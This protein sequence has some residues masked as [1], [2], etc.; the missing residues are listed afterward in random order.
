M[1]CFSPCRVLVIIPTYNGKHELGK[2]IQ[3]L[4]LQK[5]PF[6]IVVVDSS[7]TDGTQEILEKHQIKT[8]VIPQQEFNHGG[9]RQWALS[10]HPEFDIYVYM[11]QDAYLENEDA[12]ADLVACFDDP[13]VGAAYGR[14]LPH[15]EATPLARHARFFN[16]P[17][18]S[19]VVSFS[20]RESFGVKTAFLSN[21]F[22]AYRSDAINEVGG[23][24]SHTLLSEDMYV[25]AK[26]LKQ[27]W[28]VAY[29][30][31]A[32]C[33]HSHDYSAVQEWRRYFDI[34]V[35]HAQESWIRKE[36]GEVSGEGKRFVI[37]ELRF[38]GFTFWYLI[39]SAII[40][41]IGKFVAFQMGLRYKWLPVSLRR[42]FSMHRGF[43]K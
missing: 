26:L 15:R 25:A 37:S 39:P 35:F 38:L 22:A 5:Y 12:L 41:N 13:E 42:R 2:A 40:R 17:S 23:F 7:S 4:R 6:D 33:R 9:T 27:G 24:P 18:A 8:Y 29:V 30:S 28:K 31:E 1:S 10:L 43:W 34:G 32:L 36:F 3:S 16:Y 21:S 11:T 19:Y 14:Q 20:D